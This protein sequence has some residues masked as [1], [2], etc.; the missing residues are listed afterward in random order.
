MRLLRSWRAQI[1]AQYAA[2]GVV[3]VPPALP[4]SYAP[5]APP[6]SDTDDDRLSYTP[7]L[8]SGEQL[9]ATPQPVALQPGSVQLSRVW[10]HQYTS[11]AACYRGQPLD[12][13][14][15]SR[16]CVAA[17]GRSGAGKGCVLN[18]L[19][20]SLDAAYVGEGA[21]NAQMRY[22]SLKDQF[23]FDMKDIPGGKVQPRAVACCC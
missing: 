22:I 20:G 10:R 21:G 3:D 17:V 4:F 12:E 9:P 15:S 7:S 19:V 18:H 6:D 23:P 5:D 16:F 14:A 8:E 11:K 2:K 13:E 1:A